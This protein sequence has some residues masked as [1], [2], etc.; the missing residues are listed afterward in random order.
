MI[1]VKLELLNCINN[2]ACFCE[3]QQQHIKCLYAIIY[4]KE[5]NKPILTICVFQMMTSN[6]KCGN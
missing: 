1:Y 4:I 5:Q 6:R 2:N 3:I